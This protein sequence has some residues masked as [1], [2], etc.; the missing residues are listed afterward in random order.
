MGLMAHRFPGIIYHTRLKLNFASISWE[1]DNKSRN[2][3]KIDPVTIGY[4]TE[5]KLA[6]RKKSRSRPRSPTVAPYQPI[7]SESDLAT[8]YGGE[9]LVK[10]MT[11]PLMFLE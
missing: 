7:K 6:R 4:K 5:R 2:V 1:T 9:N 10:N 8:M 3:K 11:R